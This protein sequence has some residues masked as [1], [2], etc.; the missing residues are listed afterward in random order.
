MGPTLKGVAT[1][2]NFDRPGEVQYQLVFDDGLRV[3]VPEETASVVIKH[4][5][6]KVRPEESEQEPVVGTSPNGY[7]SSSE[8]EDEDIA[9]RAHDDATADEHGVSSI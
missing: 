5:M 6:R 7:D 3:P 1:E 2:T 9:I 8:Y 4:M